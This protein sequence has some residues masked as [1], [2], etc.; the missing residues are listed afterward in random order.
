MIFFGDNGTVEWDDPPSPRDRNKVKGTPYEGGVNVPLIVRGPGIRAGREKRILGHAVDLFATII[1]LAGGNVSDLVPTRTRLDS[2]SLA[3]TL[4]DADATGPR[5]WV[6]AE[7]SLGPSNHDLIRND[8][9]KLI[10]DLNSGDEE[11]YHLAEDPHETDP[12][13]VDGLNDSGR[14]NHDELKRAYAGLLGSEDAEAV[15]R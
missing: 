14:R 1:E 11:F 7:Q 6:F 8:E 15:T 4:L 5:T 2:F 10:L 13:P 9:Y 3:R 12:L